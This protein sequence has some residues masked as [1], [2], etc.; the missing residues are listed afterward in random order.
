MINRYIVDYEIYNPSSA[1]PSGW[2]NFGCSVE[3]EVSVDAFMQNIY[4]K[5][6]KDGVKPEQNIR[7]TGIFK[8]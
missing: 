2:G 6:R 7:I 1:T 5:A 4:D 8:L 3:G